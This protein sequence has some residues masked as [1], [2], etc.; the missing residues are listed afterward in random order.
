MILQREEHLR[1]AVEKEAEYR[2]QVC[3]A[4]TAESAGSSCACAASHDPTEWCY[5]ACTNQHHSPKLDT[6]PRMI[7]H[8]STRPS[9]HCHHMQIERLEA[10]FQK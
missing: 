4:Y 10:M 1:F 6:W 2:Q 7:Q 9:N 3:D 8:L 5:Q